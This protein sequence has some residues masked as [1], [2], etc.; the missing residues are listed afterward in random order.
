MGIYLPIKFCDTVIT[1]I[2]ELLN[3]TERPDYP[4]TSLD[5]LTHNK[6]QVEKKNK[7]QEGMFRCR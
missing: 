5:A 4:D 7:V 2:E 1:T 3:K 6:A